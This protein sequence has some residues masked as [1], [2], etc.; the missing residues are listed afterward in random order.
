MYLSK[1]YTT[2]YW[3]E[4]PAE[5]SQTQESNAIFKTKNDLKLFTIPSHPK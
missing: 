5:Y 3:Q 2:H 4:L 1:G